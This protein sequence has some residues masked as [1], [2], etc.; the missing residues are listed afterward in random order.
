MYPPGPVLSTISLPARDQKQEL[1]MP[2]LE[3][4]YDVPAV[5][6]MAAAEIVTPALVIDLDA[7]ERNVAT[8]RARVE[9]AG[10]RLRVHGK[11][12]RSADVAR[13]QMEYGGACGICCQKVAEA[14]AFARAGITDI[15]VSNQVR[16]PVMIDRLARLPGL[17]ARTIVCIDDLDNVAE[18]SAAAERH[19]AELEVLVE[20]DCGMGRCGV[21][22]GAPVVALAR[23]VAAAPGLRFAGIQAYHGSAQHVRTH[24]ERKA[25]IDAA[26][27]QVRMTVEMLASE[28]FACDI[29]GGAGTGTYPF[30][31]ASGVY[32]ELQC[33]SYAFM[34]ADYGRIEGANG[35]PI[36]DFDNALF[37]ATT[38]LSNAI[39]GR[40]V[41][42]AGLK[43]QSVD[44]GLPEIFGRDDVKYAGASDEHGVLADP[45]NVLSVG[46][47]LMLVPG[48]CDPTC[49]LHDWYVGVRGGVVECLWPVTARGKSF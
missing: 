14:E 26:I 5:V 19:G 13:Y 44:S 43:S 40:A 32:N 28:G 25:K 42:D 21:V 7:F 36:T 6:G 10:V 18:L 34:D 35:H 39:A 22:A 48:H 12:H 31:A 24:A 47:R 17:G 15:L 37:L 29:V 9:E 20:I 23:A 16:Q 38:I 27:E 1:E 30:E 11:M 2:Q 49:N 4:G 8:L 33:G 46:D 41:C 3:L 45:G